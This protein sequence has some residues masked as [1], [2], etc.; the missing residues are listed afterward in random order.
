MTIAEVWVVFDRRGDMP[1]IAG[2]SEAD[3]IDKIQYVNEALRHHYYVRRFV[4]P[5]PT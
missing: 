3:A 5:E 4:A 1:V 2:T